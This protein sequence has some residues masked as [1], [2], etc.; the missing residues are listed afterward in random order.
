MHF[1]NNGSGYTLF[2]EEADAYTYVDKS[3]LI[4]EVYRYAR[5]VKKYICVTKPRRFGKTVAANMIA[6]FFD[7][8]V[9]EKSRKMFREMKIAGLERAQ[10]LLRQNTEDETKLTGLCWLQQGKHKVFHL[11]MIHLLT[12]EVETYQD[13]YQNIRDFFLMDLKNA[14][15]DLTFREKA[16]IAEAISSTGDQFIFVIDEWDAVFEMDFMTSG[17]KEKYLLFLRSLLKDKSYVHFAYMTGILPIAKYSSGSPLNMF[18]EFSAFDDV[19]FSSYF[20]LS[21]D[22]IKT[23]IEKRGFTKPSMYDLTFWYDGYIRDSDDEHL[24]NPNSVT[25][26]L[27]NGRCKNYWTGTGPMNE[28]SDLIRYNV[29]DLREDVIRMV[30]GEAL[31]IDL[32]GFSIEKSKISTK[33]EILSAMVVYGFLIYHNGKLRIPNHELMLKFQEALSS[34]TLGLR[35]TL[36]ESQKLMDATLNQQDHEVARILETLH[37]EK[38]PFFVYH[39]ENSLSCVVVIGYLA[40]L[41]DYVI[42]REDKAGKGYV[43]FLF[44]PHNK[45]KPAIVLELKYNHSAK[46]AIDCI[47][48]KAYMQKVKDYSRVLLVGL[49]FSE[50]T[51]KHTCITE[52]IRGN[53]ESSEN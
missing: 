38:I 13:F 48:K 26:A 17:D 43:D 30:G 32:R 6:A 36:E 44:I 1:L 42:T 27:T 37:D 3:L 9:A 25:R 31:E 14:Y 4:D 47:K 29:H 28:V 41:N 7:E 2:R 46:N 20:G 18:D 24:F 21:V 50:A 34:E 33:N 5:R 45:S 16:G 53:K 22:E 11:N 52:M 49:N 23:L 10:E 51:K 12:P 35:Q 40:A 8:S 19:T 15:P 39:D